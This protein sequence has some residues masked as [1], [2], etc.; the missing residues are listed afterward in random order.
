M[1]LETKTWR[2]DCTASAIEAD[3]DS[4]QQKK[5]KTT[6]NIQATKQA[7][8]ETAK[9]DNKQSTEPPLP[10]WLNRLPA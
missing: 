4:A 5:D 6:T 9:H 8:N 1:N 10:F 2:R 3:A 7:S